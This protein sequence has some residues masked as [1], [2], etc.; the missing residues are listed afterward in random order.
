LANHLIVIY[1]PPLVGKS[2]LAWSLARSLPGKT[3]VVS[4]DALLGGSIAIADSDAT[5]ELDMVHTQLR[6]LVANYLKNRYHVVVEGPFRYEWD[7]VQHDFEA[8]IDQLVALMRHLAQGALVV[9]LDASPET[10][11]QRA[12]ASGRE[13]ELPV[14]LRLREAYRARSGD[15][16]LSFD[17]SAVGPEDIVSE[18]REARLAERVV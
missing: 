17:T 6:L 8:D 1:G 11:M 4:L 10:L 15:R 7:G 12:A 2:T 5:A 3:A 9:R 18:I 13:S 14:A 16:S